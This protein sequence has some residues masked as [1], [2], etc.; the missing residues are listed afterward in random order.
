[1]GHSVTLGGERLGG[2]KKNKVYLHGYE[3]STHDLSRIWRSTM[4]PGTLVPFIKELALPGDTFDI[5]LDVSALTLPTIGPLF[6]SFKLHMDV[7][8]V[9][10][11]LYNAGLHMN[12]I[13]IGMDMSKVLIPQVELAANNPVPTKPID[14]QQINPSCIFKYLGMSGLGK[15]S[16]AT[17]FATRQINAIPWLAYWDIYKTYYCNKQEFIGAVIHQPASPT[18]PTLGSAMMFNAAPAGVAIPVGATAFAS[19]AYLMNDTTYLVLNGTGG[20]ITSNITI[21]QIL[22]DYAAPAT[23]VTADTIFT[24]MEIDT[25]AQTITLYGPK[26]MN[27]TIG[28][29]RMAGNTAQPIVTPQVTTF[30]L[31]DIDT[32]RLNI[33]QAPIAT[34]FIINSTNLLNPYKLALDSY[35]TSAGPP[36]VKNYSIMYS[37]EGLGLRTYASDLHNNWINTSTIEAGPN[38]ITVITSVN[39]VGNKFTIDELNLNKKVYDMLNR[40]AVSGGTYDD[41]IDAVYE[42]NRHRGA[43]NPIYIGGAIRNIVF[44]EVVSTVD[45]MANAQQPLG[46]LA[47]RGKLGSINKGGKIIAKITEPSYIIGIVSIVPN[48]DYFQGNDWDNNLTTFNDL[49][50]PQLDQ[51]GFQNLI[52]DQM[53]WFDTTLQSATARTYKRAGKQPAW[54]NYMTAV[55]KV[56]GNFADQQNMGWMVLTRRYDTAHLTT[57]AYISD[58]TTYIDP[59]KFNVSFA[60]AAI[61]AQNFMI[62][63]GIHMIAR[64]KMSAKTIPNL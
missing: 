57:S 7:F 60:N 28:K 20:T 40:I 54:I 27:V 21:N 58:V 13:N 64:R 55:N 24:T 25:A 15:P 38:G 46:T 29:I 49:H 36:I 5:N 12:M 16:V 41:W 43:E 53:A 2:G 59:S 45:A 56:Y 9:P 48:I 50:K 1:M 39:V 3:R 42:E 17:T 10:M 8:S 63:I 32:M 51:I 30:N 22:L 47:G 26:V 35:Q 6:G 11:R 34:P 19:Q 18:S 33:L 31:A 14:N 37:Q 62:Q 44:Q 52:T 4:S 23:Y 61:D